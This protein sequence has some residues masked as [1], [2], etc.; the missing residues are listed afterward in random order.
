V[1]AMHVQERLGSCTGETKACA[2]KAAAAL[3]LLRCAHCPYFPGAVDDGAANQREVGRPVPGR[4]V[5][6]ELAGAQDGPRP[7]VAKHLGPAK[8]TKEP[9]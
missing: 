2:K 7:R 6:A 9:Q 4:G 3:V 1:S 8:K 5:G